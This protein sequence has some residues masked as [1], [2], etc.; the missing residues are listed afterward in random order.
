MEGLQGGFSFFDFL[1]DLRL[2]A[3]PPA[4]CGG[5]SQKEG[6]WE[7]PPRS[8]GILWLPVTPQNHSLNKPTSVAGPLP[9]AHTDDCQFR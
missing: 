8:R 5:R 6:G 9:P 3:F 7:G 1:A 4:F 2:Q